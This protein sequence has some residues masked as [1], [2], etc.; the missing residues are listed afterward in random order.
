MVLR[1]AARL[2]L[3]APSGSM[4]LTGYVAQSLLAGAVFHG[5]G[6]G[7]FGT[8]GNAALLGIACLI[9]LV[10]TMA[11]IL[12]RRHFTRGPLDAALRAMAG[13]LAGLGMRRR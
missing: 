3:L 11:A 7:L 4:P 9:W 1:L 2:G 5:W 12:W 10:V 8:L 6:L 13:S